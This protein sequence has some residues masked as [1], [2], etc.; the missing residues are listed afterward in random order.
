MNKNFKQIVNKIKE[1]EY[2]VITR[3][4]NS[5]LDCL[6]SQFALKEWINLNF[7]NKKVYCV[8]ENHQKYINE[9]KFFP[10]CDV[11]D[12]ED[13]PYLAICVDVNSTNRI[14]GL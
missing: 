1:Y 10:K 14:L 9:K 4:Q 5:D 3:H 2:I 11:F 12:L 13:K 6:G 8:G 7:N